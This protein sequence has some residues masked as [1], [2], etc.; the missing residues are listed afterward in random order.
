[1]TPRGLST[2]ID[3]EDATQGCPPRH[4]D[5]SV[6]PKSGPLAPILT[7]NAADRASTRTDEK[8]KSP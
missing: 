1:M 4:H 8:S 2:I 5:R 6:A 3:A 7:V